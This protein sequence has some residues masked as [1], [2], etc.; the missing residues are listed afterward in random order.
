VF[1]VRRAS[2]RLESENRGPR[3]KVKHHLVGCAIAAVACLYANQASA[4]A[5]RGSV[6]DLPAAL[7][8]F[9]RRS[10]IEVVFDPAQVAGIKVHMPAAAPTAAALTQLLASTRFTF[11]QVDARSFLIVKRSHRTPEPVDQPQPSAGP[12]IMVVGRQSQNIDLVR[13]PDEIQPYT[14]LNA[15][16]IAASGEPTLGDFLRTRLTLDRSTASLSQGGASPRSQIDVHGLGDTQTLVLV[17]GR[18]MADIPL[19]GYLNGQSD[20]NAIPVEAV[21]RI[22]VLATSAGG[23]FGIG[24]TGGAV[25]IVLKHDYNGAFLSAST[26]VTEKGD[27]IE[28]RIYGRL[29]WSSHD[30]RT[31]I[32]VSA[33]Y[34]HDGGLLEQDRSYVQQAHA[35]RISQVGYVDLYASNAINIVSATGAPLSLTAAYG[36]ASLGSSVTFM[37]V[38]AEALGAKDV[39]ALIANA[40]REDLSPAT[41]G[42]GP[43]ASLIARTSRF[44]VMTTLRQDIGDSAELFFDYLHF[45]DRGYFSAPRLTSMYGPLPV[46]AFGNPFNQAIEVSFPTNFSPVVEV[47]RNYEQRMTL[48]LIR[49]FSGGWSLEADAAYGTSTYARKSAGSELAVFPQLF[50]GSAGLAAALSS[51][52]DITTTLRSTDRIADSNIRLAGPIAH[53]PGGTATLSLSGEYRR[54]WSKGFSINESV[55]YLGNLYNFPYPDQSSANQVIWSIFGELRLP[56]LAETHGVSPWRGLA[57]QIALRFDRYA[58]VL[59]PLSDGLGV[60]SRNSVL[61]ATLGLQSRPVSGLMLRTSL[62]TAATPPPP[63]DMIGVTQQANLSYYTDPERG[64]TPLGTSVTQTLGNPNLQPQRTISLSGGLVIEPDALP[65]FRASADYTALATH[66]EIFSVPNGIQYLVN[67]EGDFPGMVIRAPLTAAD[68]ALG[69]TGGAITAITQGAAQTG[70][71]LLQT[72]D[73][74]LGYDV[75]A[76]SGHLHLRADTDWVIAF[77]R[78]ANPLDGS[79]DLTGHSD[80][81]LSWRTD[82]SAMWN[83][84]RWSFGAQSQLYAGYSLGQATPADSLVPLTIMLA[85]SAAEPRVPMQD[86]FDLSFAFHPSGQKG[87]QLRLTIDNIFNKQPPIVANNLP[88]SLVGLIDLVP[89]TGVANYGDMLGRRFALNLSLPLGR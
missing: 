64:G 36:G 4:S 1:I 41:D 62:S 77:R 46:G 32:M 33:S 42:Q 17:D 20:L 56:I 57:A 10:G 63:S 18:R 66:H 27:G 84:E 23:I 22:E 78:T 28:H 50:N 5:A 86:Y 55:A 68:R 61:G 74:V 6:L 70:H 73:F 38:S 79:F 75:A 45:D 43:Q 16:D 54:E 8:D 30:G 9:A 49:R 87:W 89:S 48:G 53:L 51:L 29:G 85:A 71:S 40:G 69:Y 12:E 39:A 13:G 58:L 35:K 14:V 67:Y 44:S 24:A 80:G 3:A 21:E 47:E 76:G 82:L 60:T 34:G 25:N 65:G 72:M 88:V 83:N 2:S 11:R 31:R 59:P 52:E 81:P 26:G 7:N 19:T 37:P 15:S